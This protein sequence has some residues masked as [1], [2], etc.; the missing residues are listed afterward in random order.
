MFAIIQASN[1][2]ALQRDPSHTGT[3]SVALN[4]QTVNAST[5]IVSGGIDQITVGSTLNANGI[6]YNVFVLPGSIDAGNN[7]WSQNGEFEPVDPIVPVDWPG[8]GQSD[9]DPDDFE[10]P[11]GGGGT[12]G[13]TGGGDPTGADFGTQCIPASTKVCQQA[14]AYI[15]ITEPI[16]NILTDATPEAELCRLFYEDCVNEALREFPWD[17]A[18]RY[19]VMPRV[20]GTTEVPVNDDW[21]Y[22]YR[23]PADCLFPRRLVRPEKKRAFDPDPPMFRQTGADDTGRLILSNWR[24]PETDDTAPTALLEYTYRPDCAA[25]QGDALFRQALAWLLA[26]KIAPG[27]SRNKIT[28]AEAWRMFLFTVNRASTVNARAQQQDVVQG[29]PDWIRGRN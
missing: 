7:G 4:P 5:G 22:S 8:D 13:D 27:V 29:D 10:I 24:D 9:V 20:V 6:T 16:V 15:G 11:P 25:G 19:A 2:A 3:T 18:T 14:M 28:A 26:S 23:V 1:G 17:F 21:T 12:G